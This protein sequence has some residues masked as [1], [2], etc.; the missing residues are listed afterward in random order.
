MYHHKRTEN[1]VKN[2]RKHQDFERS[3]G[4]SSGY[5]GFN[6]DFKGVR[7]HSLHQH[8][9]TAKQGQT[10]RKQNFEWSEG[11]FLFVILV[12]RRVSMG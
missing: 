9:G 8:K 10:C 12:L 11:F 3:E 6:K 1:R 5:S 4:F 2:W 7:S